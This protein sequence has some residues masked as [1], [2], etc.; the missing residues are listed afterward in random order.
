M[1]QSPMN[2]PPGHYRVAA[3]GAATKFFTGAFSELV[4]RAPLGPG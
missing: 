4:L 1:K 3:D 2:P